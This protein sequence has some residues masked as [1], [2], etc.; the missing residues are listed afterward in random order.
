MFSVL[1]SIYN[2]EN[3]F[4]LDASLKS[5]LGQTLAPSEIVLNITVILKISAKIQKKYEF[6]RKNK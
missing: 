4:F 3:P 6:A 2:K 1:L 5:V